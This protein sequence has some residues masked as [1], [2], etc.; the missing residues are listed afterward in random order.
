VITADL[1]RLLADANRKPQG[2]HDLHQVNSLGKSHPCRKD[3]DRLHKGEVD[4][5]RVG[6]IHHRLVSG[7]EI[8]RDSDALK[9]SDIYIKG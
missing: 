3:I 9:S 4:N 1:K 7:R 5:A 6:R 2:C 8:I